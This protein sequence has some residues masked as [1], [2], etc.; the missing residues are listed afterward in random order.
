MK[1][2]IVNADDFGFSANRNRGIIESIEK[3]VVTSVS[4]L[5]GFPAAGEALEYTKHSS[6]GAAVHLNLSEGPSV[7]KGLRTL[8]DRDGRFFGKMGIRE[9]LIAGKVD[10]AE[11]EQEVTAQIRVARDAGVRLTHLD[12]HHHI[13]VYPWVSEP[14]ARAAEKCGIRWIRCPMDDDMTAVPLHKD[15]LQDLMQYAAVGKE[16]RKVF[17]RFGMSFTDHFRG[18]VLSRAMSREGMERL[19]RQLPEGSSELMMHPGYPDPG[20]EFSNEDRA[21][22]VRILCD[23][24]LR[25]LLKETGV[26]LT[27]FGELPCEF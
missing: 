1:R 6:V 10:P 11:I 25:A 27:H 9:R 19:L 12:G 5:V 22:E 18:A 14:V 21:L 7:L 17:E 13:H 8:T 24:S 16:A 4:L 3:G 2:L 26:E 15:R 23:P 20:D